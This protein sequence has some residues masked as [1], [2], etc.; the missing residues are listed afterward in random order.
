MKRK[1][2]PGD[3]V[4]VSKKMPKCMSHFDKDFIGCVQGSYKD[5]YGGGGRNP[6]DEYS[7]I[8][9]NKGRPVNVISWYPSSVLEKLDRY[10]LARYF[11]KHI[12]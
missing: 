4:R 8:K 10:N 6:D 12:H 3:F 11:L 7:I 1:F 2:K 5:L 9:F